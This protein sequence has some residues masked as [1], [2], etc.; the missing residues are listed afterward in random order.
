M[1][2]ALSQP[3]REETCAAENPTFF[4]SSMADVGRRAV[5]TPV[6]CLGD[7]E[8]WNPANQGPFEVP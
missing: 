3:P 1:R 4:M 2:P 8:E 6:P 5:E 7:G